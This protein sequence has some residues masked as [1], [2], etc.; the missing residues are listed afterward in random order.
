LDIYYPEW[1]SG[2]L[3]QNKKEKLVSYNQWLLTEGVKKGLISNKPKD[4]VWEE[5]VIHSL[6]FGLIINTEYKSKTICDLGT[7]AGIPGVPIAIMNSKKKVY[8][9]DRSEKRIFELERLKKL[10]DIKNI[11][12]VLASAEFFVSNNTEAIGIYVSRC[13]M[14]TEKIIKNIFTD[15]KHR[16]EALLVSSNQKKKF[17]ENAQFHVKQEEILINKRKRRSIDVITFK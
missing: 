12:P 17:T 7:G 2:L 1:T 4:Y 14:P 9:V 16:P 5:F 10:F 15:E 3:S 6:G 8:L 13:F 11:E